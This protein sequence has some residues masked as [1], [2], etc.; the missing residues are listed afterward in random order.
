MF[1]PRR[2]TDFWPSMNT[3]AAGASPVPGSEMPMSAW[4]DSPGPLTTQPITASVRCS[5]PGWVIFHSG[6]FARTCSWTTWA[7]SWKNSLVV[8][9]QPGHAVTIGVNARRPI[10]RSEEHTSELQSLMRISYAVF[11]LKKKNTEYTSTHR[12]T[13][14]YR[15]RQHQNNTH[16]IT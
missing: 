12:L 2:V 6:I 3:G 14:T 15:H 13:D 4:R 9:P 8:R 11:C 10:V 5:A 7:S 1:S 16:A